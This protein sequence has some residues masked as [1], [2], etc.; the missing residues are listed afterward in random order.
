MH[1]GIIPFH[2]MYQRCPSWEAKKRRKAR[3]EFPPLIFGECLVA[4][5]SQHSQ[6]PAL[7]SA[8]QWVHGGVSSGDGR[9]GA[10]GG[11]RR[12]VPSDRSRPRCGL[13][14]PGLSPSWLAVGA[15]ELGLAAHWAGWVAKVL[16]EAATL[17]F[18]PLPKRFHS[19]PE[20]NG[21]SKRLQTMFLLLFDRSPPPDLVLALNFFGLTHILTPVCETRHYF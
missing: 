14:S 17:A 12:S 11:T 10:R 4:L 13:A 20:K 2:P 21:Q 18:G 3:W 6:T 8:F 1:R 15:G 16:E 7:S 19:A 9:G 5:G